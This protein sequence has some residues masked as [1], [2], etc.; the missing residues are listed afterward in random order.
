MYLFFSATP[1]LNLPDIS[2][3]AWEKNCPCGL[4]YTPARNGDKSSKT[5]KSRDGFLLIVGE[6]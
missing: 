6:K 5:Q 1:I 2:A 4:S 3:A